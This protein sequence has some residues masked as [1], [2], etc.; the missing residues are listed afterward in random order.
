M[1]LDP[2]QGRARKL[3]RDR[4]DFPARCEFRDAGLGRLYVTIKTRKLK[5][6]LADQP[7]LRFSP[8]GWPETR[9]KE[10]FD[11]FLAR[12]DT[13]PTPAEFRAAGLRGLSNALE[14]TVT[15]TRGLATTDKNGSTRELRIAL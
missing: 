4:K 12:R 6:E 1:E 11:Q 10:T 3:R 5:A 9:I 14:R 8:R 13:W 7:G 15:P 2:R